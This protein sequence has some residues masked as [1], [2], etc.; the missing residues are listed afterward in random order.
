MLQY[1]PKNR[2]YNHSDIIDF[3]SECRTTNATNTRNIQENRITGVDRNMKCVFPFQYKQ[4][5]YHH[6]TNDH[7][8]TTCY[9]CGT[10]FNVTNNSGWG[11][12]NSSCPRDKGKNVPVRV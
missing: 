4:K 6:C 11:I 7:H 9:W 2:A 3:I 8:C 12:C 1:S 10:Q 5:L